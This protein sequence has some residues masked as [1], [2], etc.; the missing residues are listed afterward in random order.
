VRLVEVPERTL[1]VR[2][3]SWWATDGRVERYTD[4][5]LASLEGASRYRVVGD[6]FVFQYEGPGVPP[7]L[8]TNEVAVEVRRTTG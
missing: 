5:L 8:R 2:S 1:A 4:D 3:F 7:F 6:P